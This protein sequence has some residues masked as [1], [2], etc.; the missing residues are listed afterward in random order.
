MC[1]VTGASVRGD[2]P[3]FHQP[4]VGLQ[5]WSRTAV[6]Q[7]YEPSR[8]PQYGRTCSQIIKILTYLSNKHVKLVLDLYLNRTAR[9][10]ISLHKR[11][12]GRS[13]R[14]SNSNI[15]IQKVI[16]YMT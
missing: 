10:S 16:N 1:R 2:R 5:R 7:L 8:G 3:S 11:H 9:H 4:Q 15:T 6:D 12:V 14:R 13:P